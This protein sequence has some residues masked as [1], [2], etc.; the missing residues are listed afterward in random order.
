MANRWGNSGRLY[1]LAIPQ[2]LQMVNASRKLKDACF[3]EEI[4]KQRHYFANRSPSNHSY[5]SS[6]H[7]TWMWELDYKENRAPKNWWFWTLVLEKTLESPLNCKEIQPVHPKGT[8][9]WIFT[10]RTDAETETPILWPPDVKNWLFEKTL[11]LNDWRREEKETTEDEMVG[12]HHCL[13][14]HEFKHAPGVGNGQGGLVC[15][16]PW[17]HRVGHDW[18]NWTELG[19]S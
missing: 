12:W 9:S 18:L 19:W 4:K 15:C 14:A 11:M 1:F 7:H 3:L 16:S 2:S 17:G 5:G 6:S 8:Q 10:G 13:N